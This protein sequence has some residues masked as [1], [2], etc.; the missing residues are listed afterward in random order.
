MFFGIHAAFKTCFFVFITKLIYAFAQPLVMG[1]CN[2][3]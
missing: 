1:K 2:A 3:P